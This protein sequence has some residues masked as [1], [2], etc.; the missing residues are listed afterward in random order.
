VYN[1]YAPP[2]DSALNNPNHYYREIHEA[3]MAWHDAP[4][5]PPPVWPNLSRVL[6]PIEDAF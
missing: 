4:T 3:Y 2:Y 6:L 5:L 1:D